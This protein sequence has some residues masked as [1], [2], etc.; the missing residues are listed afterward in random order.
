MD[1]FVSAGAEHGR[2]KNLASVRVDDDLHHADGFA[3]FDRASNS[4]HQTFANQDGAT[5]AFRFRF[6]H[7][8]AAE[9]RVGVERVRLNAL[10]Y[11][12]S[13]TVQQIGRHDFEVVVGRM[14]KRA[15]TIAIAERP[16]TRDVGLQP[17]V[18]DDVTAL[19]ARDASCVEPQIVRVGLAA[20]REK[21]MRAFDRRAAVLAIDVRD[22]GPRTSTEANALGIQ[23]KA[24]AFAGEEV[25][26]GRRDLRVFTPT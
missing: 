13:L 15:L 6:R 26:N 17:I 16:D 20:N 3:L 12:A 8:G 22:D 1:R 18:H 24:D 10:R 19:I 21:Q 14:G 7:A 9:W 4:C 23:T 25:L 5:T 2:A 11:A